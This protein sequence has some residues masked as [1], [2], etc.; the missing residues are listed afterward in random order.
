MKY[1][2]ILNG[3]TVWSMN[4]IVNNL[5]FFV[6]KLTFLNLIKSLINVY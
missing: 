1:I 2:G 3:N 6:K 4:T 5:V